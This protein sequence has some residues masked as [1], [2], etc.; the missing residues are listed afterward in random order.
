MGVSDVD[1]GVSRL[2]PRLARR[3]MIDLALSVAAGR[4]SH[5]GYAGRD[6]TG[7]AGGHLSAKR[8][9]DGCLA[10]RRHCEPPEGEDMLRALAS[11]RSDELEGGRS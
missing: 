6:K 7:G 11:P 4:R 2:D 5:E 8:P 3:R 9:P 10:A 1:W